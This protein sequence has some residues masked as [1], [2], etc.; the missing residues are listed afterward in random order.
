MVVQPVEMVDCSSADS[1]PDLAAPVI[2]PSGSTI[3]INFMHHGLVDT[4]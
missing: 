1:T 3:T 4:C 2:P